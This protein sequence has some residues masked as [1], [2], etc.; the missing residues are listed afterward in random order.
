MTD[1]PA[2]LEEAGLPRLPPLSDGSTGRGARTIRVDRRVGI[3]RRRGREGWVALGK[4][5][6]EE[7]GTG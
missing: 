1:E 7:G 5:A 3:E 4:R 6:K 2:T